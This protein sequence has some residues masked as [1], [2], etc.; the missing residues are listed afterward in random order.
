M[1]CK[2]YL[3][4]WFNNKTND[5]LYIKYVFFGSGIEPKEK[6]VFTGSKTELTI[7]VLFLSKGYGK[8]EIWSYFNQYIVD[9]NGKPVFAKNARSNVKENLL[10]AEDRMRQALMEMAGNNKLS[11]EIF[12]DL[13]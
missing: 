1:I 8:S 2:K 10:D 3:P 11:K 5:P 12:E 9:K 6:M 7:F 13:K 4:Q